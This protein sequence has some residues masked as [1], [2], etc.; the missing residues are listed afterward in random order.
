MDYQ[1][2]IERLWSL[3]YVKLLTKGEIGAIAVG[4]VLTED[5]TRWI[6]QVMMGAQ[7][8]EQLIDVDEIKIEKMDLAGIYEMVLSLFPLRV[9][10]M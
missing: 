10:Q 5:I 8:V 9:E 6:N 2:F 4:W 3:K 1:S 7:I